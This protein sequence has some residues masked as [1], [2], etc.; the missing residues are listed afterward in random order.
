M[1]VHSIT[2]FILYNECGFNRHSKREKLIDL[3][4]AVYIWTGLFGFINWFDNVNWP[5]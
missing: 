5:P 3:F 4:M 1:L 2:Y